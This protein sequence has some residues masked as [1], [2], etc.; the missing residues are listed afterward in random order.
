MDSSVKQMMAFI[1][2]STLSCRSV[3]ST[4]DSSVNGRQRVSTAPLTEEEIRQSPFGKYLPTLHKMAG[5]QQSSDVLSVSASRAP[6]RHRDSIPFQWI[7]DRDATGKY[8]HLNGVD[9]SEELDDFP[10]FQL[11]SEKTKVKEHKYE[12]QSE[13]SSKDTHTF[14]TPRAARATTSNFPTTTNIE[15][16]TIKST[17][18]PPSPPPRKIFNNTDSKSLFFDSAKTVGSKETLPTNEYINVNSK[19][20]TTMTLRKV[21]LEGYQWILE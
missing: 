6:R 13:D 21:I 9:L 17:T 10:T 1:N 14:S 5:Q 11:H 2:S 12:I 18:T 15:M 16:N 7:D 3:G 20:F 19:A 4:P 8:S